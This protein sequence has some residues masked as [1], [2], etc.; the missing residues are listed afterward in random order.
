MARKRNPDLDG[1]APDKG[2]DAL[3]ILDMISDYEFPNGPQVLRSALRIANRIVRLRERATSATVPVIYVNDN[4]GR[5]RSNFREQYE[6]SVSS[7]SRGAPIAAMLRPRG[8]DYIILKP[9]HSGFF[10]TPLATLLEHLGARRLILT[11]ISSHQCV[12]FTAT[13]AYVRDFKLAIP[14]DCIASENT[15]MDKLAQRYLKQVLGASLMQSTQ[16]RFVRSK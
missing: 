5:W 9:R 1:V 10:A 15:A 6:Q 8:S 2:H 4:K 13:D 14:R 11:G 7:R 3:L 16:L 12:L